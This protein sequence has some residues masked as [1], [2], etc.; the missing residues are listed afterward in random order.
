MGIG[1]VAFQPCLNDPDLVPTSCP[2]PSGATDAF[3]AKVSNFTPPVAG[4]SPVSVSLIYFSYLGGTGND[5]GTAITVD[6]VGGARVAGWTDSSDFP[7][8]NPVQA[9]SG[10]GRDAF[11]ANLNTVST[12][13][14]TPDPTAVPPVVCASYSSFLGGSGTDMATGIALDT[15]GSAYVAGET[16]STNFP[17]KSP[18]Q[19]TFGGVSDAFV[20]KLSP[21]LALTMT[22]TASPSPVGVGNAVTYKYTIVNNG[23]A[24]NGVTFTDNLP[25]ASTATF[26]SA[27]ASPGT[28]G[29]V[30]G[31]TVQC[32]IGS[33]TTTPSGS[34]GP[35]ISVLLTP[36]APTTPS[37]TPLPS[38]GNSATV[39]VPGLAFQASASATAVVNDFTFNPP[40]SPASETVVNGQLASYTVQVTP[41]GAIPNTVA[42]AVTSTL[43]TGATAS[44]TNA[45]LANLNNGPQSSTLN[46]QTTQRITTTTELRHG[47]GPFYAL[48]LPVTGLAFLGLAGGKTSHRRRWLMGILA[49]A[50]LVVLG[51]SASCGTSPPTITT[52]ALPRELTR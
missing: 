29:T 1:T 42:L 10:G 37:T 19:A 34:T 41:T 16:T 27:T 45:S 14:C 5:A 25:S 39:S 24:A 8:Q 30:N 49:G 35:T 52:T 40:P 21:A 38:L 50:F 44:F 32:N 28:C 17:L 12:S 11:V 3:V 7:T 22:A 43:P 15:Q 33:V 13:V 20:S 6:T 23:D 18:F 46:I 31:N 36:V 48:L 2:A 26:T 9:A 51:L 4:A 47:G